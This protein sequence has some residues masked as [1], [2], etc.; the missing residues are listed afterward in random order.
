M[1]GIG[2]IGM[3]GLARLLAARGFRV[4]G[5][6]LAPAGTCDWLRSH[7]VLVMDRHDPSH[8]E[9]AVD[10]VVRTPAVHE[11]NAEVAKALG[12]GLP[13][14]VRGVA[15]A[16]LANRQRTLAVSGTHGKTTTSAMILHGLGGAAGGAG[17]CIGGE[18]DTLGN[19]AAP[20]T[21]DRLVIEADESDGTLAL[22]D[23]NV[24]VI[25]NIE[26]DHVDHFA[27][28]E[29]ML[30]CFRGFVRRTRGCVVV[31]ADDAASARIGIE[32]PSSVSYGFDAGA[33]V[34]VI[35]LAPAADSSRFD[36]AVRGRMF[37]GMRLPVPG[38]HNAAN[39]AGAVAA[40]L[41]FGEEPERAI[42]RLASFTPVR[43][44]FETVWADGDIAVVTDYAHHPTEIRAVIETARQRHPKRIVVIF[45]PHRYSRTRTLLEDFPASFAGVDDLILVPVY[46]SSEPPMEGGRSEDLLGAV[47]RRGNVSARL[48]ATLE[49]AWS[50]AWEERRS[51]DLLL[52]LGAGDIARVA[53]WAR[54]R[55]ETID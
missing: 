1:V 44:R 8:V 18:I 37:P 33:D 31:C 42:R 6:E 50:W 16:A 28:E 51:G 15:L 4:T 36:L 52:L 17:F 3:A 2:G 20:G 34:R 39:A 53:G 10:F 29:E 26:F 13:V 25:T 32:P 48:A 19:V 23:A 12:L 11:G 7:G 14:T 41:A 47:R 55:L 43:R 22:Y 35:G 21:D 38:R 49:T 46:A 45:Q 24:A 54:R 27:D 9:P 40:A 30:E 5:S